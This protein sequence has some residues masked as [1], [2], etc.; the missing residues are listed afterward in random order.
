MFHG[1]F[2]TSRAKMFHVKH[3]LVSHIYKTPNVSRETLG[4]ILYKYQKVN[5]G[6]ILITSYSL[7]YIGIL[8]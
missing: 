5:I 8:K 4:S 2:T 3:Y 6:I 7:Q 1:R